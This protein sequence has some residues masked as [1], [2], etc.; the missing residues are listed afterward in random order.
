MAYIRLGELLIS[1]GIIDQN[2]LNEALS[3]Q[4]QTKQ[5]LGIF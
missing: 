5:R 4:K 1:A 3:V 2:Q